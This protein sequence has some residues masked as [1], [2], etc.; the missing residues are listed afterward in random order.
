MSSTAGAYGFPMVNARYKPE[1]PEPLPLP[2]KEPGKWKFPS[3]PIEIP[4]DPMEGPTVTFLGWFNGTP[5]ILGGPHKPQ[6]SPK[7]PGN[8][9]PLLRQSWKREGGFCKTA[10]LMKIPLSRSIVGKKVQ[11]RAYQD[12]NSISGK[13]GRTRCNFPTLAY[14]RRNMKTGHSCAVNARKHAEPIGGVAQKLR[15]IK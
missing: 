3:L 9:L 13:P 14:D 2:D 1:S 12:H 5:T 11:E 10:I 4:L 7:C 8:R 6:V 15:T